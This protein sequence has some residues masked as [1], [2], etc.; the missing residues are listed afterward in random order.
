MLK[1]RLSRRC[2]ASADLGIAVLARS[3][4]GIG[5][6]Q[7]GSDLKIVCFTF[8]MHIL[9]FLFS[10]QILGWPRPRPV[11]NLAKTAKRK[12]AEA[13]PGGLAGRLT[14][15]QKPNFW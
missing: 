9:Y 10:R 15:L 5:L 6:A 4:P 2:P 12:S 7:T 1:D 11:L 3:R 8:L 14:L 13:W